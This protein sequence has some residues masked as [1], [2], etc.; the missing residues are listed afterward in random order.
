ME[1]VCASEPLSE[2]RDTPPV[3]LPAETSSASVR[4]SAGRRRK[5]ACPSG[6]DTDS[7]THF[8]AR[9]PSRVLCTTR[10]PGFGEPPS[11]AS[12]IPESLLTMVA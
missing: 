10:A 7:I 6:P 5:P 3:A 1:N 2:R 12:A 4:E 11:T 8:C 9:L